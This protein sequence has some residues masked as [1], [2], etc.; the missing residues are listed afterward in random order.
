LGRSEKIDPFV[1]AGGQY[2]YLLDAES[3]LGR[4]VMMEGQA[5]DDLQSGVKNVTGSR[6]RDNYAAL[7]GIGVRVK[8]AAGYLHANVCYTKGLLG[9]VKDSS[10]FSDK[11][12]LYYYNYI[13][14]RIKL[15]SYSF[16]FGYSYVFYKTSKKSSL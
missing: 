1:F 5:S 9:Y 16:S 12:N 13:D 11:E 4:R 7:A 14:D 2:S 6:V 10:R 8:I 3:R 15:D